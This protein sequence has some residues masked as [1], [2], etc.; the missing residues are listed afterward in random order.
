MLAPHELK[1]LQHKIAYENDQHAFAQLYISGMPFLLQFAH[2]IIKNKELAEE[3]TKEIPEF[4]IDYNPD[5]RQAIADSWPASIDD[6]VAKKDWGLTYDFGISEMTKDMI[7]NL[8]VKLGK[9]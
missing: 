8:K 2:S 7:K 9:D 4:T 1:T 3:I 6:S 5:F